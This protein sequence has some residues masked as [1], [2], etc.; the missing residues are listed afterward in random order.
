MMQLLAE[1]GGLIVVLAACGLLAGTVAGLFGI[2]GG[3]VIVPVLYFAI[4]GLG[5]EQTAQHT[6]V[7][8]SLATIILTSARSV[9]AHHKHGAV[10]WEIIRVWTPWIMLGAVIGMVLASYL[11]ATALT[12]LFGCVA[13]VVSLQ[14]FFGRPDWKIGE[15]MPV[16]ATRDA[17][18]GGLGGLSAL[19][20]VG[21]G[22]FGVS[23]MTLYGRKIHN[24]VATGAG[25]GIA[26]G[27]PATLTAVITGWSVPDRPPFSLGYVNLPA[28]FLI[29]TFTVIMAPVGAKMAHAL[30]AELLKRMF[31]LL[32][33]LV[34]ARMIWRV[35]GG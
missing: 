4:G 17:L 1:Y 25:F 28:F 32:L 22:T 3:A 2:G 13:V 26:I 19:M 33:F 27:L 31:G 7:A 8:T 9:M 21:G 11:S 35:I 18:G 6:A 30:N 34:A 29:S 10:S 14:F 15:D 20:G 16:G 12:L 23:L 5:Y 24:A